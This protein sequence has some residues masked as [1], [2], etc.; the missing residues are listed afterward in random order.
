MLTKDIIDHQEKFFNLMV[1]EYQMCVIIQLQKSNRNKVK[2]N[3][4]IFTKHLKYIN[5]L[6]LFVTFYVLLTFAYIETQ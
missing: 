4:L 2:T 5:K 1:T 6:Y 3:N